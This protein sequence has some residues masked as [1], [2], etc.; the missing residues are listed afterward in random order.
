M[1]Q[2]GLVLVQTL[3]AV[4]AG[5][6]VRT[7][8]PFDYVGTD[9][10]Y[11]SKLTR[12]VRKALKALLRFCVHSR[13]SGAYLKSLVYG[14]APRLVG[15]SQTRGSNWGRRLVVPPLATVAFELCV[16]GA[17]GLKTRWVRGTLRTSLIDSVTMVKKLLLDLRFYKSD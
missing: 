14:E 10:A 8:G 12:F 7:I 2:E 1:V 6:L 3:R 5:S 16:V 9:K 4:R 17:T 13:A 15:I 11:S